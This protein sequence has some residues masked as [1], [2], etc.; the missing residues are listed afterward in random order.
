[1]GRLYEAS[2]PHSIT[3]FASAISVGGNRGR[4]ALAVFK[5]ITNSNLVDCMTG[6]SARLL[7]LE[8]PSDHLPERDAARLPNEDVRIHGE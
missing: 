8:N 2:P 7:A 5:L 6:K 3:S 4:A 1:M